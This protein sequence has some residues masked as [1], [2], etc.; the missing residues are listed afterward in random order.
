VDEGFLVSDGTRQQIENLLRAQA[1]GTGSGV[2]RPPAVGAPVQVLKIIAGGSS[3]YGYPAHVQQWDEST[4]YTTA[5]GGADVVYVKEQNG[6]VPAEG[7]LVTARF[8]GMNAGIGCFV[9]T[10]GPGP[11]LP[12]LST[13]GLF[14]G[15]GYVELSVPE[16]GIYMVIAHVL[17][18]EPGGGTP[19]C[20][21]SLVAGSGGTAYGS[22]RLW[23]DA[24]F[25]A[26][27]Y[28]QYLRDYMPFYPGPAANGMGGGGT[29]VGWFVATGSPAAVRVTAGTSAGSGI[30][31]S[32]HA[33]MYAVRF[34]NGNAAGAVL[35]A[36][37]PKYQF[38][39]NVPYTQ[40]SSGD[41]Y[42]PEIMDI[43]Y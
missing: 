13:A 42:S 41:W 25:G 29:L 40:L 1:D 2:P 5:Y 26:G 33:T 19:D 21:A 43:A 9:S 37:T 4:G 16:T 20:V 27:A 30:F 15:G 32:F 28:G 36:D 24:G 31:A 14:F 39:N 38:A 35:P 3:M 6:A 17:G 23:Y 18:N 11:I 7:D 12:G 10:N 8:V 22:I 34:S